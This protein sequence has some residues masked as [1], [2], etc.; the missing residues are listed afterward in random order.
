LGDDYNTAINVFLL[1]ADHMFYKT[2]FWC[3][4]MSAKPFTSIAI[5]LPI[6][7]KLRDLFLSLPEYAYF[8]DMIVDMAKEYLKN[9]KPPRQK[10][11]KNDGR[12]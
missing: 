10:K 9:H 7:T 4:I 2:L 5:P 3:I 6:H 1:T 12:H 11:G 8:Q